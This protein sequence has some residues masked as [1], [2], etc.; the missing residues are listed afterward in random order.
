MTPGYIV[1]LK[2][3]GL[4]GGILRL[5]HQRVTFFLAS[6]LFLPAETWRHET[7]IRLLQGG[8]GRWSPSFFWRL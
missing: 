3:A 2:P 4:V 6:W 5:N 8:G 7:K 1:P